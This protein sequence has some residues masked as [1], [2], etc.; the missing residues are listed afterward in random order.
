LKLVKHN[1]SP[2]TIEQAVE[3]ATQIPSYPRGASSF[4]RLTRIPMSKSSLQGLV[5]E[6][7]ERLVVAQAQ[8]AQ[9]MVQVPEGVSEGEAWRAIPEPDSPVM[10]VAMDGGMI[11]VR[12]EGWKETKIVAISAV[13]VGEEV[14]GGAGPAVELRRTSYRAGLWDAASFGPQQW[15]EACRRGLEKA[16]RVVCVNDGAPWIWLI[17]AMCYVPCIEVLDWWHAVQK[18]WE[19]AFLLLGAENEAS[20]V[21]AEQQKSFLWAGQLRQVFHQLRLLC[22]RGQ[23]LPDKVPQA[24]GYLF[25]HRQR[26]R[27]PAFRHAGYPIGSGSVESA[28][29]VVVQER[30]K[31]AGMTWSRP[32][33]QAMLALR[34]VLLSGRWT[35][36]W[37]SLAPP[38]LT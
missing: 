33:A 29:K 16:E 8:E 3:L 22:P 25:R 36:V 18:L 26:M 6:Y 38:K 21:W 23:A 10:A 32:G 34:S 28:C 14:E 13:E 7:G 31:Q 1:W 15:A 30:M 12:G 9:A 27:Y 5:V 4:Q 24:I 19:L 11:H 35:E 2:E 37:P 17:V 20:P